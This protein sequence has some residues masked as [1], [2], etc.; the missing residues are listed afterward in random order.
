M[1][2]FIVLLLVILS[3]VF[4]LAT[5]GAV[6]HKVFA[7][8]NHF[9]TRPVRS[10]NYGI[11]SVCIVTGMMIILFMFWYNSHFIIATLLMKSYVNTIDNPIFLAQDQFVINRDM[12]IDFLR[13]GVDREQVAEFVPTS[14]MYASERIRGMF[15]ILIVVLFVAG[16]SGLFYCIIWNRLFYNVKPAWW[17]EKSIDALFM[18]AASVAVFI[19]FG[20][21]FSLMF[22]AL[23]FFSMVSPI[24]FLFGINWDPQ[25]HISEGEKVP[26]GIFGS[27]PVFLGTFLVTGVAVFVSFPVGLLSAIYLREYATPKVRTYAKPLLELLAGIPTLVY[28]FFAIL[29]FMPAIGT[30]FSALGFDIS[31]NNA[32]TAGIVMGIMIIP[33][34]SSMTDDALSQVPTSIREGALAMGATTREALFTVLLPAAS[35]GIFSGILLAVSRAVGETMIVVMAA[36]FIANLT[37]NPLDSVTTASV[38]IVSLLTGDIA[39]DSPKTLAAF[40]LGLVLFII[41]FTLNALAYSLSAKWRQSMK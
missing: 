24:D 21:V 40:A 25:V 13:S 8:E 5:W 36:G 3:S 29:V 22:E 17:T 18:I 15:N 14:I 27:V 23:R 12:L 19:T 34:V 32:L 31:S 4:A 28:G 26:D 1:Y 2:L 9:L 41:T 16:C 38:Q 11:I 39:F 30:I 35:H 37:V 7:S 20:I 10:W 6:K 33:F